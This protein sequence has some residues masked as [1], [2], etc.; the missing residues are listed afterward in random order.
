M[1]TNE[2]LKWACRAT[3]LLAIVV[4][5]PTGM[6]LNHN[7]QMAKLDS[8]KATLTHKDHGLDRLASKLDSLDRKLDN[9]QVGSE[10]EADSV[11]PICNGDK[12]LIDQTT[13]KEEPCAECKGSGKRAC[14]MMG[15]AGG[16]IIPNV[17]VITDETREFMVEAR[18]ELRALR[19]FRQGIE[20][21]DISI[22]VEGSLWKGTAEAKLRRN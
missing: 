17:R 6:R 4:G 7:A 14:M 19:E 15:A 1:T 13:G 22:S 8:I 12:V 11:C 9:L 18:D 10:P 5:V 20:R 3:T 2:K 16:R 21:G